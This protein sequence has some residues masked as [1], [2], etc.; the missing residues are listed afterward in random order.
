[1]LYWVGQ[2][3]RSAHEIAVA[4]DAGETP[5]KIKGSLR[6]PSK[7]ADRL[8]ADARRAGADRLRNAIEQMADL[9]LTSRGGSKGSV[10]EETAMLRAIGAIAG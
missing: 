10:S 8:I 7:A 1:M 5:A 3:I 9:E 4:L 6:M 2:R